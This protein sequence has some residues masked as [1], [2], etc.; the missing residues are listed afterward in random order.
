MAGRLDLGVSESQGA[1]Q[2]ACGAVLDL[3]VGYDER[4]LVGICTGWGNPHGSRVW[5][6]SGYGYGLGFCD[7][8]T[9]PYPH[10]TRAILLACHVLLFD[11]YLMLVY[12]CDLFGC[13]IM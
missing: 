3:Y 8:H 4:A 5:V 1:H 10:G 7:P 6:P 9:N 11:Y 2:R 12:Y 13:V